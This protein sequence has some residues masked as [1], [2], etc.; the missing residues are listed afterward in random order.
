MITMPRTTDKKKDYCKARFKG[1]DRFRLP[2]VNVTVKVD[3]KIL[4]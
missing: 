2:R 1:F 3:F 4:T